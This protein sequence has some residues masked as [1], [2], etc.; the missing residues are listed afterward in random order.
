MERAR[1]G[2]KHQNDALHQKK[3]DPCACVCNE[4]EEPECNNVRGTYGCDNENC[5]NSY[6][7]DKDW[8]WGGRFVDTHTHRLARW[9]LNSCIITPAYWALFTWRR[10]I[11]GQSTLPWPR[12][13]QPSFPCNCLPMAFIKSLLKRVSSARQGFAG[14]ITWKMFP[15]LT[16]S[17]TLIFACARLVHYEG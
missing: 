9:A 13:A 6:P 3:S 1:I 11:G 15:V 8:Q 5:E 4:V 7:C 16:T 10:L 2:D 12:M 17:P 14:N